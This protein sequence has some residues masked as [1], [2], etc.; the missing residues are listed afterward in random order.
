MWCVCVC[1]CAL[2]GA[3]SGKGCGWHLLCRTH[4]RKQPASYRPMAFAHC[5]GCTVNVETRTCNYQHIP[6]I[7]VL[8]R[9]S[10][11]WPDDRVLAKFIWA[12][13]QIQM[14]HLDLGPIPKMAPHI[15]TDVWKLKILLLP[16][17]IRGFQATVISVLPPPTPSPSR[18]MFLIQD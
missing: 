17:C 12:E 4:R 8:L 16:S 14:S 1:V 18:G 7:P 13:V 6:R 9:E 15:A 5:W 2:L 10:H 11:T 3:G